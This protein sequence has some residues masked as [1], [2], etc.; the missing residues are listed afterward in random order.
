MY[1]KRIKKCS[2]NVMFMN[3][4]FCNFIVHKVHLKKAVLEVGTPFIGAPFDL[5]MIV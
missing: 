1:M 5:G 4:F 3:K 2:R